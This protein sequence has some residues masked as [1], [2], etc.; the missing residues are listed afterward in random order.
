LNRL[1]RLTHLP[2]RL[3]LGAL[4]SA[5]AWATAAPTL[6]ASSTAPSA[7]ARAGSKKA[8]RK[9][10]QPK[11]PA[12][13]YASRA[14]VLEFADQLAERRGLDATWVR[15]QLAQAQMQPAVRRLI[16]PA[17]VGTAKNWAA[18]RDRFIE[19]Q[20]IAAGLVFWKT[21]ENELA[22]AQAQWGVPPEMVVAIVGVET[23]YGRVMGSFR[24]IDSLATLSFD[25]PPGRKDRSAFFRTELEEYL[26]WCAREQRSPLATMG[27]YA[28]AMGLPQFMPSSINRYAVDFDGDGRIDLQRNVADVVGS[29]ARYFSEQGWK[30]G[31]PTHYEVQPPAG[32]D[33]LAALRGPDIVP[34]FSPEQFAQ[35][36][37]RLSEAGQL[38]PGLLALV[39]LEND[40]KALSYFAGTSNFYTV[41][42]YN[43]SAYY[44]M[45]VI[46]LA[47]ALKAARP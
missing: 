17:P 7:T 3:V 25:F 12:S 24:V 46:L 4:G 14:D 26:A 19:P 2:R 8:P 22:R 11:A 6:A 41:T 16:M 13:P 39:E 42:R 31:L 33:D 36:G 35:R 30:P 5:L 18:Y 34:S 20:R 1:T 23:F 44:A 43:W 40:G 15:R 9:R 38:H 29:V 28:G 45:A 32:A 27:S 10:S 37:A 21:A 47:Q